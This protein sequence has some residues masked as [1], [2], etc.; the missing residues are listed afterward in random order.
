MLCQHIR[1]IGH[2]RN[3]ARRDE[4]ARLD[5]LKARL[6]QPLD[7]L[8]LDVGRH[9]GRLVLQ[10]VARPDLDHANPVRNS[11]LPKPSSA[12]SDSSSAPS[13]TRS[14][15]VK[16]TASTIPSAGAATPCS[17]FIASSA[18]S[19]WPRRTRSPALT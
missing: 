7:E 9:G 18:T 1:G 13:S 2:L 6:R 14:P 15:S 19:G 5:R 3:P 17:I 10:A 8:D 12:V 11:Q 16:C 4:A